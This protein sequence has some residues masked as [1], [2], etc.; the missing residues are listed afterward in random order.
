MGIQQEQLDYILDQ[1]AEEIPESV[2]ANHL[3]SGVAN[4]P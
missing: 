2:V 3:K 4:D 1:A